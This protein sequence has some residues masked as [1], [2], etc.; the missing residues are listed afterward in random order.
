MQAMTGRD[1][2]GAERLLDDALQ[3]PSRSRASIGARAWHQELVCRFQDAIE[4]YRP[5]LRQDPLSLVVSFMM[6]SRL[7]AGGRTDEAQ[8]EFERSKDLAGDRGMVELLAF[9]RMWSCSGPGGAREQYQRFLAHCGSDM[10]LPVFDEL[11]RVLLEPGKAQALITHAAAENENRN[12]VRQS[13]LALL[14][15]AFGAIDVAIAAIRCAYVDFG[16]MPQRFMWLPAFATV[17]KDARFK[18]IVRDL[19]LYDYWRK[20]GKWG[21]FARPLGEDDFQLVK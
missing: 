2:L 3:T 9:L 20:T 5:M 12:A 8:A 13:H 11:E 4:T 1:Y 6:Q 17:R 10:H 19:G 18:N 15:G 14:A 7:D 21:D 16:L